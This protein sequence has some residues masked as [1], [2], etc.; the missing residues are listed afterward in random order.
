MGALVR[1]VRVAVRLNEVRAVVE[2]DF[3][4]FR[5][6][7]RHDGESVVSVTGNALRR[8]WSYCAEAVEQL[9][10][11]V[12][13]KLSRLGIQVAD[14]AD[15]RL[16]CTHLFDLAGL[17]IATAGR[18]ISSLRYD[19]RVDDSV[20]GYRCAHLCQN[21]I[22]VLEWELDQTRIVTSSIY[23]DQD[24]RINFAHWAQHLLSADECEAALS[25]RRAVFISNGRQV[26]L[27]LMAHPPATGGCYTLQPERAPTAIRVLG[28][29]R[30]FTHHAQRPTQFDDAWL[31]FS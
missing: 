10:T 13:M 2:D 15:R 11:L 22:R 28:S 30:D 3:H 9:Y 17:A 5:V 6:T 27:D 4:H 31:A 23:H 19:M 8:P 16:Q 20:D 21:G 29:T 25:L 7:V 18:G 14:H 1:T 26:N 24:L 12:G